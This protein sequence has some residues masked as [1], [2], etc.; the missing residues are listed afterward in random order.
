MV[1][2]G[3]AKEH[4]LQIRGRQSS[5]GIGFPQWV[6]IA[7]FSCGQAAEVEMFARH[8]CPKKSPF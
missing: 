3:I 5:H 7:G 8:E 6:G 1:V 2:E 4:Q